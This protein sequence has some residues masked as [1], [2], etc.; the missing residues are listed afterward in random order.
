MDLEMQ[1]F[2]VSES[3]NRPKLRLNSLDNLNKLIHE[4]A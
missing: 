4:K 2:K 1:R 3:V